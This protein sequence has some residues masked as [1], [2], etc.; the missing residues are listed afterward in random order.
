MAKGKGQSCTFCGRTQDMVKRLIAG[1]DGVCICNDCIMLCASILEQEDVR[2]KSSSAQF[3]PERVPTPR[4]I[5]QALDEAPILNIAASSQ[6]PETQFYKLITDRLQPR[7]SKLQGVGS[8]KI[9]GGKERQIKVNI[10]AE[11]LKNYHLSVLQ[12]LQAIQSS[13]VPS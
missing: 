11:K 4:E 12:V 5:K 9:T 13:N 2:E 6:M 3:S 10:D 7:L 1:Q 8:V